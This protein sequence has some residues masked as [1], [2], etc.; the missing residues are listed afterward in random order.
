MKAAGSSLN[1]DSDTNFPGG[2]E[3]RS[4]RERHSHNKD[5][6]ITVVHSFADCLENL[7]INCRSTPIVPVVLVLFIPSDTFRAL[8]SC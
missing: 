4:D 3:N 2:A 7:Q 8:S 6:R 1:F 5:T